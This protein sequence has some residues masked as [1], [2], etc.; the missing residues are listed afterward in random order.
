MRTLVV[1]ATA[2][3]LAAC[4][5]APAEGPG[6]KRPAPEAPEA[7]E[8]AP[9]AIEYLVVPIAWVERY[10]PAPPEEVRQWARSHPD[11]VKKETPLE[12]D[13][14]DA[15][16]KAHAPE[17]ARKVAEEIVARMKGGHPTRSAIAD[18]TL[19]VLGEGAA[20]DA[21]RP[22]PARIDR[23]RADAARVPD[24][25]KGG[26]RRFAS[27]ANPGDVVDAPLTSTRGYVVARAFSAAPRRR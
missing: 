8:A 4:G 25:V 13:L 23:D 9:L 7:S 21:D 24:D 19:A 26:F 1:L 16:R 17:A 10:V 12:E 20:A 15:Y 6:P 3:V 11:A 14:A 2:A 22:R 18:A 27:R 5:G